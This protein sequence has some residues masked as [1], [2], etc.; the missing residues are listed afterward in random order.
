MLLLLLIFNN[1]TILLMASLNTINGKNRWLL[2]TAMLLSLLLAID[3]RPTRLVVM[4][5]H[6]QGDL[7]SRVFGDTCGRQ[8][9]WMVLSQCWPASAW[10]QHLLR[11]L[12]T[13]V[14]L[15]LKQNM[16]WPEPC[17]GEPPHYLC[18]R[19]FQGAQVTV[20]HC[21][22]INKVDCCEE[23]YSFTN[24]VFVLWCLGACQEWWRLLAKS[25]CFAWWCVDTIFCIAS[26]I[27]NLGC[28]VVQPCWHRF[29]WWRQKNLWWKHLLWWRLQRHK[30]HCR[31]YDAL[32]QWWGIMTGTI[33]F[34]VGAL[35]PSW[36]LNVVA[37]SLFVVRGLSLPCTVYA[38]L[39][40]FV[41]RG[42][43]SS[44]MTYMANCPCGKRLIITPSPVAILG[45]GFI[46]AVFDKGPLSP[47]LMN[48]ASL[49]F[50][51]YLPLVMYTLSLA[52]LHA[53]FG[54]LVVLDL[55]VLTPLVIA[56]CNMV[57]VASCKQQHNF[58][59]CCMG[60]YLSFPCIC[61]YCCCYLQYDIK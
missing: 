21:P 13:A 7:A 60:V 48:E 44:C 24:Q 31:Q 25:T 55:G 54:V 52:Y 51:L 58:F 30:L 22:V 12:S 9:H 38:V 18:V 16:Q 46:V 37:Q 5:W 17:A 39:R 42:S 33:N 26:A 61:C 20:T 56:L 29:S 3:N 40:P 2:Y 27:N 19:Y 41:A 1:T 15:G 32:M 57:V 6:R 35:A 50:L 43:S 47:S 4:A 23:F 59:D 36:S 10:L 53:I 49:A 34:T 28:R 45:K 11:S 8:N 14:V